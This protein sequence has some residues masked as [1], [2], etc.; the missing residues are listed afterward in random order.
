MV[1]LGPPSITSITASGSNVVI[2]FTSTDGDDSTSS[3][4]LQSASSVTG[5]Y[6]NVNPAATFTQDPTSG[7]FQTIYPQNGP[8]QFYR[9]VQVN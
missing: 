4:I 7:V 3:F 9:I 2:Q 8:A 5:P 6:V 1:R